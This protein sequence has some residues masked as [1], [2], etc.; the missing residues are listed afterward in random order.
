MYLEV[1]NLSM[2]FDKKVLYNNIN[3]RILPKEKV[4]IVGPNGVGKSTLI[5]ILGGEIIPDTGSIEFDKNIK[6]GYLD[7]YAK[8]D[9]KKRIIEYLKEAFSSLYNKEEKMKEYLKLIKSTTDSSLHTRYAKSASIIQE[10]LEVN[11]F[12]EI[13]SMIMKVAKGL[14]ITNYG[15][16]TELGKLSGGQK[17]KVV[18]AKLLLEDPDL[19]ILDEP[20]NFLDES[21][22]EWL[23]KYLKEY[24]GTFLIVSHNQEFL[25][26]VVNVILDIDNTQVKKYKGNYQAYEMKKAMD[27][28]VFER[29][30][31]AQQKEKAKLEDYI[32]RNRTRASTAKMAQ[33]RQKKLDKMELLEKPKSQNVPMHLKFNY[34]SISSH[35]FLVVE[36]LEIGYYFSLLPKISFEIKSGDRIAIMG[37]NGI[38]KTTLLK[39]LIG[40]LKPIG[41]KFKFVD[42]AK[43]AYFEQEHHFENDNISPLQYIQEIYPKL[44]EKEIRG[45]LAKSGI[46]GPL[47]LQPIKTMSGGEQSKLKLCLVTMQKANVLVLDEP[48]NHLDANSKEE[49]KKAL[50]NYPGTVIFVSHEHEFT[51]AVATKKFDIEELLLS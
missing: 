28:E 7:Q 23:V 33:S 8:V 12:Y 5:K 44:N 24:K 43:I 39:T 27:A 45:I 50:I 25:N 17:V 1:K 31:A 49:L 2:T 4:G 22:V 42:D 47:A 19:I 10:E 38:G 29:Q 9:K 35:R 34:S 21:H 26:D 41:G 40:E 48:T 11:R 14:G 3:F 30:Y 15:M 36:D 46:V 32:N 51:N 16:Q 18:L 6:I 13:D 37:F 20:T